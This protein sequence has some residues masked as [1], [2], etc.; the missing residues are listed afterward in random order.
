L[1]SRATLGVFF[2]L[3]FFGGGPFLKVHLTVL[4][5]ILDCLFS[6]C[7]FFAA[8][9]PALPPRRSALMRLRQAAT[10][11][12]LVFVFFAGS[13]HCISFLGFLVEI[14]V[15]RIH[16]W[17]GMKACRK[18]QKT[19]KNLAAKSAVYAWRALRNNP[20]NRLSFPVQFS[21]GLVLPAVAVPFSLWLEA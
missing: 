9:L 10:A 12:R 18:S 20:E 6:G 16:V 19:W 15:S 5:G 11:V 8:R 13:C 3:F 2:L 17:Y 7:L 1:R 21:T 4:I 14:S